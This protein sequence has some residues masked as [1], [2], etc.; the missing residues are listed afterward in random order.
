M[1]FSL[2]AVGQQ[3]EY[4]GESYIKSTPLIAH[5]VDTGEQR[6]I[7]RS[8]NVVSAD[9]PVEAQPL[10]DSDIEAEQLRD[11]FAELEQTLH[12]QLGND[13]HFVRA[14]EQARQ[15]FFERL[16]LAAVPVSPRA[17]DH[18]PS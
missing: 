16:G 3:F 9:A 11:A 17:K 4:Q 10:G 8:A 7:P 18:S 12:Q 2:L 13:A 15:R 6:L 1:K 5:Q 14:F